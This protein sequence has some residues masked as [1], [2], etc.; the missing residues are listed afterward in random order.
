ME[1]QQ[2]GKLCSGNTCGPGK[3]DT[4]GGNHWR[5]Q[6]NLQINTIH[7]LDVTADRYFGELLAC[8]GI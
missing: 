4:A 3:A 8:R 6:G 5:L 2:F 7:L 1:A